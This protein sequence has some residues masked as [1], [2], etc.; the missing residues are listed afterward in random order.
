[1][2]VAVES[3]DGKTIKSPLDETKGYLIFDVEDADIKGIEYRSKNDFRRRNKKAVGNSNAKSLLC[4]CGIVI[5]R[6]MDR[7]HLSE[8]KKNGVDVFVTFNKHAEDA[9]RACIK[10]RLMTEQLVH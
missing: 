9:L 8:L 7:N 6:G 2:K 10:E 5:T 4:D 1:M 3:N